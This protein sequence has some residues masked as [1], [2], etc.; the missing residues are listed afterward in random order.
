MTNKPTFKTLK[1]AFMRLL[2]LGQ[3]ALD[4]AI[5]HFL[6]FQLQMP[7]HPGLSLTKIFS[8]W[9]VSNSSQAYFGFSRM[10]HSHGSQVIRAGLIFAFTFLFVFSPL[11]DQLAPLLPQK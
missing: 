7:Y 10:V 8:I 3:D 2:S 9:A 6:S 11:A 1:T 4:G 5:S